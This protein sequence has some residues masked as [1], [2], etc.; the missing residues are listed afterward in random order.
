MRAKI[1][2]G[3]WSAEQIEEF[4]ETTRIPLRLAL[5][6]ADGWPLVV[7]LWFCREGEALWCATASDS[8]VA[9]R[10]ELD[11]RCGF[12]IATE[13]PPYCGLRGHADVELHPDRGIEWRQRLA[14]RYLGEHDPFVKWLTRQK[15][16][17]TALRIKPRSL[18]SWDYRKRMSS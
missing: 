18:S 4:L 3:P 1:Q 7:S 14:V 16:P 15:R 10:L 11:P 5:L 9:K 8:Y 13:S 2:S 17:E 12:E 6:R